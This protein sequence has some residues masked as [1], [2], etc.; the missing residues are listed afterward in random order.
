V[1]L[2]EIGNRI[3]AIGGVLNIVCWTVAGKATAAEPDPAEPSAEDI[4]ADQALSYDTWYIRA[5]AGLA[6]VRT[7]TQYHP[8]S[9]DSQKRRLVAD[10]MGLSLRLGVGL[11]PAV[12]VT[13]GILG[14]I[15]HVPLTRLDGQFSGEGQGL[16]YAMAYVDHRLPAKILRVGGGAGLG[17]VYTFGPEEE[18]FSG[19]GPVG[20]L[21]LALDVPS[22]RRVALGIVAEV[23][24]SALR[25]THHAF[26]EDHDFNTFLLVAGLSFSMR[27][28]EP[29]LPKSMPTFARRNPPR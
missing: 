17:Q 20:G 8:V 9:D 7:A 29:S 22:S 11:R 1:R 14:G 10:G 5:D 12:D 25:D 26:G 3:L 16:Y 23:T 27:I 4:A 21:W 24:G 15:T 18:N 2:A 19:L 6:Y 28:S 13:L